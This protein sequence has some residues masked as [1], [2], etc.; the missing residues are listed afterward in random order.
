MHRITPAVALLVVSACAEPSVIQ[1]PPVV[2]SSAKTYAGP[3]TVFEDAMLIDGTGAPPRGPVCILLDGERIAEVSPSCDAIPP[4]ATVVDL[5]GKHV[6]PE[7]VDTHVHLGILSGTT[8]AAANYTE[9][10]IMRQMQRFAEYGVGAL[11]SLGADHAEILPIR[12]ASRKQV[13][14]ILYSALQGFGVPG[15][16]P[17]PEGGFDQPYRPATADEAGANVDAIAKL[18]PDIIKIWVDDFWGKYPKMKPEVYKAVIASAHAHNLRVAAHVY[19]LDDARALVALGVDV[20][21]HSVRDAPI[22]DALLGLMKASGTTYVP[23][24]A[25]DEYAFAYADEA[26]WIN[27]PFFI[28]ALE[29]GVLQMVTSAE[30]KKKLLADPKTAA[31]RKAFP[32]ALKNLAAVYKAGVKVALGTDAGANPVRAQG[33]SEHHELALLVKAG[34]TPLEAIT[35]ATKNGAELLQSQD[36]GTLEPGKHA[37]FIVLDADPAADIANTHTISSVWHRGTCIFRAAN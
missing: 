15:G 2:V 7:L 16:L 4:D 36:F 30:Y 21:A 20:I 5:S 17:P 34:L 12:D 27:D 23:T 1:P 11:L 8:T 10:N 14:P 19:H 3:V 24:L 25:I 29:P 32:T 18:G 33:Y 28:N 9:A 22:D 35:V 6:I 26:P 31:E 37:S 13:G